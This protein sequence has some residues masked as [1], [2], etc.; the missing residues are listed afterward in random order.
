MVVRLLL[1]GMYYLFERASDD[2][3]FSSSCFFALSLS[4]FLLFLVPR[5]EQ[6]NGF[7][8]GVSGCGTVQRQNP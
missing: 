4:S 6:G 1:R 2:I 5:A 3:Y 7:I 8:W